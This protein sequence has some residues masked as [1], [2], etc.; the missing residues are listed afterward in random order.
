MNR[1]TDL[2]MRLPVICAPMFRISGPEMVIA[3]C[4]SGIGGSFPSTNARTVDELDQ[5]MGQISGF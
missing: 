3:A 5:W 4:K 1:P 2:Q